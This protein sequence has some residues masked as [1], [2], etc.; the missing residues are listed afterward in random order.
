[1]SN[2]YAH[3]ADALREGRGAETE[4]GNPRSGFYRYG[5]EA[6]AIWRHPADGGLLC[7]RSG[8]RRAP[9]LLDEIDDLFAYCAAN[10]ISYETFKTVMDTGQW[11]DDAPRASERDAVAFDDPGGIAHETAQLKSAFDAFIAGIGR[12]ALKSDA[13]RCANYA[14]AFA[15]QE[16]KAEL[17]RQEA[18]APF[19][20]AGREIDARWK[21]VADEAAA[22]K[23][24]AKK[25]LEPYL[26]AERAKAIEAY[27]EAQDP[28]L[29]GPAAVTAGTQGRAVTL[30]TR[31]VNAIVDWAALLTH[32]ATLN[33]RPADL[34]AVCQTCVNRMV[35]KGFVPPGVEIRH[36]EEAA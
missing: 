28:R 21:P 17:A 6:I 12:V 20:A 24:R 27:A 30:R 32:F 7:S 25:A 15:A 29:S 31:Q 8:P 11:P 35:A 19:L 10:P 22:A 5:R 2:Q 3:W 13:D 36:I 4:P 1:M 14:D 26:T 16:R 34:E 18:K 9:V 33:E 23:R